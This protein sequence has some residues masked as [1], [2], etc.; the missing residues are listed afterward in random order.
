MLS[1]SAG[2]SGLPCRMYVNGWYT[3]LGGIAPL[4]ST[5]LPI[6]IADM[7]SIVGRVVII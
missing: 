7:L 1:S 3:E 5:S 6:S 4:S 2:G